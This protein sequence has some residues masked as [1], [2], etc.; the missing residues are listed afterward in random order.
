[1]GLA[2]VDATSAF[3]DVGHSSDARALLEELVIGRAGN[4]VRPTF[5]WTILPFP[6]KTQ[7]L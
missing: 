6:S 3:E 5:R 4:L 1:M 7:R 2:G